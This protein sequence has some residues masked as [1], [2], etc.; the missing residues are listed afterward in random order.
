[1]TT[2]PQKKRILLVDD[3]PEFLDAA[4]ELLRELSGGAWDL[5]TCPSGGEAMSS[6]QQTPIDLIVLDVN[7][8]VLDGVQLLG[9]LQRR[10]PSLLKIVLTGEALPEQRAA[11]LTAGAELV[12]DKPAGEEGWKNIHAALESLLHAPREDGF[13][14]VLRKVSLPDVIQMECLAINSSVLEITGQ[15]M[16]GRLFIREGQI[17]HGEIGDLTGADALNHLLCLPGGSF[18]LLPFSDPGRET[19]SG[20]WEFLLMEA[21]RVRDESMAGM[22]TPETP[23]KPEILPDAAAI[24]AFSIQPPMAEPVPAG[25]PPPAAPPAPSPASG[26]TAATGT[27][28]AGTTTGMQPIVKET[29]MC[30]LQGEVLYQWDCPNPGD[31]I[32]LLEFISKRSGAMAAGLPLGTFERFESV[33]KGVRCVAK[34]DGDQALFVRIQSVLAAGPGASGTP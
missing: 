10:F 25:P 16:R 12:L 8:P 29:L 17:I 26:E 4:T 15:G 5:L 7:M 19:I 9:L 3:S 24:E 20:Q 6:L 2:P 13:R 27:V 30:S 18:H 33:D 31:R 34:I 23:A 28:P 32:A 14:G 22:A 21:A 1:M 11:C